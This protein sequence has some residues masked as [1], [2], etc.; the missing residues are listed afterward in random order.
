MDR[1]FSAGG[2][3]VED[4]RILLVKVCNL[5]GEAVWTFP[6]GHPNKGETPLETALR[7]VEEETGWSCRS[8]G[9]LTTLSYRFSRQGR[10]VAKR[11]SW[12]KMAPL[13]EVGSPDASEVLEA[14]W[15]KTKSAQ[16]SLKYPSDLKLL[17]MIS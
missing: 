12:F 13:K 2:V 7:E 1:E 15:V 16:K 8:L 3:V 9:P 4:G 5:A 6:K 10:P 17:A 14:K 11:V